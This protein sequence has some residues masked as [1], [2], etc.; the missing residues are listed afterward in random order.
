MKIQVLKMLNYQDQC[1]KDAAKWLD[2]HGKSESD[3]TIFG[4]GFEQGYK[5]ALTVLYLYYG[6]KFE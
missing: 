6:I 3:K 4:Y 1:K 2:V 5:A